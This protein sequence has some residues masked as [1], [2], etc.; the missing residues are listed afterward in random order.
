MPPWMRSRTSPV[1]G[2]GRFSAGEFDPLKWKPSYPNDAFQRR[3]PEDDFWAARKVMRFTEEDIRTLVE[4]GQFTDRRAVDELTKILLQRR[5]RIGAAFFGRVL[6][7][8]EFR[9]RQES[10]EFNDLEVKFGFVAQ[11]EYRFQWFRFDN[12]TGRRSPVSGGTGRAL[13]AE[14][15]GDAYFGVR[16]EALQAGRQPGEVTVYFR[17]AGGNFMTVGIDRS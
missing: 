13:P 11:R 6:P 8:D 16:I 12:R 5:D 1:R 10:L 17:N 2:I 3:Q 7:L 15:T 14:L 9:L 4:T